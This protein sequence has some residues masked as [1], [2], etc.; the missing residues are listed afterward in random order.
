MTELDRIDAAREWL[1]D[2]PDSDVKA[3]ISGASECC[4]AGGHEEDPETGE[5][6][7]VAGIGPDGDGFSCRWCGAYVDGKPPESMSGGAFSG[8]LGCGAGLH[9]WFTA[10]AARAVKPSVEAARGVLAEREAAR[11]ALW[12]SDP[13]GVAQARFDLAYR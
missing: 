2:L 12:T 8:L 11:D 13:D 9:S 7:P 10:A 3:V 5:T 1:H 6:Y 4:H